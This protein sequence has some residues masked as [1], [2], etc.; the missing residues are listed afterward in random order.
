MWNGRKAFWDS[1]DEIDV[2]LYADALCGVFRFLPE[3]DSVPLF[4]ECMEPERSDAV[5]TCVVRASL[6]LSQEVCMA[7]E[8]VRRVLI[9]A[10]SGLPCTDTPFT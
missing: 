5:K 8:I 4:M 2:A 3:E 7:H 6:T 10:F 1:I 9:S